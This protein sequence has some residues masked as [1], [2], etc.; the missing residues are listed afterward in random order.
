MQ[1]LVIGIHLSGGSKSEWEKIRAKNKSN[2]SVASTHLLPQI[3]MLCALS[4]DDQ[5][6]FEI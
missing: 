3:S 4:Q 2:E 6:L 1:K 5:H